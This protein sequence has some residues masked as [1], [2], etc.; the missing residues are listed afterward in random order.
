[1]YISMYYMVREQSSLDAGNVRD[2]NT[3]WLIEFID[4]TG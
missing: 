3:L 4:P 2:V 1:M